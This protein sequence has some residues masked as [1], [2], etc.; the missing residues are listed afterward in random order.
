MITKRE[1]ERFS[2]NF[3]CTYCRKQ[4]FGTQAWNEKKMEILFDEM[5]RQV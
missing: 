1:R 5:H 4:K 3:T 2:S